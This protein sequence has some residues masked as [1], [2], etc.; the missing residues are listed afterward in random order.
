MGGA[1]FPAAVKL[2]L[3][4]QYQV[5][6]LVVNGAECEPYVS[7]D[8]RVMREHADEVIDGARI[9]AHVLGASRVIV[10]IERN[11]PQAIAAMT[12][13]ASPFANVE[14]VAVPPSTRWAMRTS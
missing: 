3:G 10:G 13:A 2:N 1:V 9:T 4:T 11:K 5:D 12:R 6:V 14:V 8:D 7:C